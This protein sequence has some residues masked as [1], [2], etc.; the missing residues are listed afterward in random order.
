MTPSRAGSSASTTSF[1]RSP[2]KRTRRETTS[3]GRTP[4]WT[5]T[6][7]RGGADALPT[8]ATACASTG[9]ATASFASP[10]TTTRTM[11][12]SA[13]RCR[14]SSGAGHAA[15]SSLFRRTA[16]GAARD[17]RAVVRVAVGDVNQLA[18]LLLEPS[19]RRAEGLHPTAPLLVRAAPGTGKTFLLKQLLYTLATRLERADDGGVPLVPLFV[20]VQ[21]LVRHRVRAN[22]GGAA[23]I[24]AFFAAEAAAGR[25]DEAEC[26][27]V[28]CALAA[29]AAIVL[30]DGVDEAAGARDEVARMVLDLARG[31][32]RVVA[33]T[34]PEGVRLSTFARDD[35][36][37]ADLAPLTDAQRRAMAC[38]LGD[39]PFF[40]HLL[41]FSTI[42]ERQDDIYKNFATEEERARLE[43]FDEVD[44]T[45][46]A[47]GAFD[48]G[49]RVLAGAVQQRA[50][51]EQ[52]RS[53][54]LRDLD[55]FLAAAEFD[56][57]AEAVATR[58]V[59]ACAT[60]CN[61]LSVR[62][63]VE[64]LF[65]LRERREEDHRALWARI[66][67]CCDDVFA[68]AEAAKPAFDALCTKLE[69]GR[70]VPVKVAPLKDPVRV[71]EKA[72]ND[73][74]DRFG[75][76]APAEACLTDLL[77][78]RIEADTAADL[79]RVVTLLACGLSTGGATLELVR[80]KNRCKH[81]TPSH[82][83]FFLL[84]LQ[85]T[86]EGK[87]LLVVEIQLHSR[88]LL[89]YN[90]QAGS[91]VHYEY[92]RTE[93]AGHFAKTLKRNLDFMVETRLTLF[94]EVA[95]VPV[96]LSLLLVVLGDAP[97]RFPES[98]PQ[99][100]EFAV[101]AA[102]QRAK[103]ANAPTV[104]GDWPSRTWRRRAR[105]Y[106]RGAHGERRPE[107]RRRAAPPQGPR[108]GRDGGPD[109]V[110]ICAFDYPGGT[111]L[112]PRTPQQRRRRRLGD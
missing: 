38:L 99:L 4:S 31:G 102:T 30:L 27:M 12:A 32:H 111:P 13:S 107:R 21:L 71:H 7:R 16:S 96:L 26:A 89:N 19:P 91:H 44:Q 100:Y 60:A 50:P 9:G 93:L 80:L 63:T 86:V 104:S 6:G 70:K 83:R 75:D 101:Q 45:R 47:S 81:A 43:A 25:L 37:I 54:V 112:R 95:R 61:H 59:E 11:S 8:A 88:E 2:W 53:A 28:T 51:G 57:G 82:F 64:R 92:F 79:D 58:A 97:R 20:P 76:G 105:V 56:Q 108:R 14:T 98:V 109:R 41:A 15:T 84:N 110:P 1:S 17:P 72:T 24:G 68:A 74:K 29:R 65:L 52:L 23:A 87:K 3:C 10:T 5:A 94:E 73:Y 55:S 62:D 18:D 35:F 42:R 49:L 46:T 40:E 69:R 22:R 85:L 78:A 103:L 39:D 106:G 48:P 34:R 66:A 33:T 36:C 90:N 77:R 67:L